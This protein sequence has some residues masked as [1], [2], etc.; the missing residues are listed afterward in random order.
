MFSKINNQD[1]LHCIEYI[2]LGINV[3]IFDFEGLI[4]ATKVINVFLVNII[5][6]LSLT[7]INIL[8]KYN[9]YMHTQKNSH[10][11]LPGRASHH[12]P[13]VS[14]TLLP[15]CLLGWGNKFWMWKGILAVRPPSV[16]LQRN[17]VNECYRQSLEK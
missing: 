8:L 7:M 15:S 10:Y 1:S 4:K 9:L 3:F 2:I 14:D 6:F 13:S 11:T 5:V 16:A 17:T 12:R